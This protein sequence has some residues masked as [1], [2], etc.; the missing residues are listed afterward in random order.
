MQALAETVIDISST[1]IEMRRFSLADINKHGPWLIPRMVKAYPELTEYTAVGWL[2]GFMTSNEYLALSQP[3][4]AALFQLMPGYTLVPAKVIQERFVWVEN[5]K[6]DEQVLAAA[7]F[8][9][10]AYQW[11]ERMVGIEH[12]IVDENSDVPKNIIEDTMIKGRKVRILK[13]EMTYVRV[14]ER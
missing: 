8:Y 7:E 9:H 4:G 5:P 3:H 14:K 6:D 10:E 13:R 1:P 12:L 11:A 2:K